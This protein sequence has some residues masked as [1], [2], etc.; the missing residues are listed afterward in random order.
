[1]RARFLKAADVCLEH[2]T[3]ILQTRAEINMIPRQTTKNFWNSYRIP[4]LANRK[5]T[6][7]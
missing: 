2:G 5:P 4:R 3:I 6:W 7:Y 1:M